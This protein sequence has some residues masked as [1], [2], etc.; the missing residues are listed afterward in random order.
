[1]L[2]AAGVKADDRATA[3]MAN[4]RMT[5]SDFIFL[6]PDLLSEYTTTGIALNK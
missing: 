4:D 6:S 5:A 3:D 1:L 2:A